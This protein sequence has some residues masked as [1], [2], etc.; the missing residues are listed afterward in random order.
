MT[1]TAHAIEHHR[2]DEGTRL[3]FWLFLYTELFLFAAF[4]LIYAVYRSANLEDFKLAAASLNTTIGAVNTVILLT[5]SLTMVLSLDAMKNGSAKLAKIFLMV[6]V[7]LGTAF[8]V[9]KGFEWSAKFEHHLFLQ[10]AKGIAAGA[11][12]PLLNP[13]AEMLPTGQVLFYGLYFIMTGIHALHIVIGGVWMLIV[14]FWISK[15]S[16]S[17]DNHGVLERCGL[18]WHLVDVI[19]IFLF[20]LYYLVA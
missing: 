18:Y 6:T 10:T 14:Y 5:S 17:Q 16:I 19:W 2:D 1:E 9:I 20:P 7:A 4:F 11:G 13:G 12:S 3:G 15:G 8:L